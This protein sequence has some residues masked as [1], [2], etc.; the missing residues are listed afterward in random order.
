LDH[1]KR[2]PDSG[3]WHHEARLQALQ[4]L[5]ES[6]GSEVYF[7]VAAVG[8]LVHGRRVAGA[9]VATPDGLAAILAGATVEA[10][11]DGILRHSPGRNGRRE[12]GGTGC[13]C[14]IP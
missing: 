2:L 7:R 11:G 13:A 4:D 5:A 12:A 14:I 6:R 3:E 8:A 10:T 9:L 1:L